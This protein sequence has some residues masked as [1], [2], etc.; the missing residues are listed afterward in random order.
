MCRWLKAVLMNISWSSHRYGLMDLKKRVFLISIHISAI[1]IPIH[2]HT[3]RYCAN[4]TA[5]H[6]RFLLAG[7]YTN[8]LELAL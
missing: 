8:S 7:K 4:P 1:H 6:V 3:R 5:G 2:V